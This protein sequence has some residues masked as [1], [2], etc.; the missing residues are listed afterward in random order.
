MN[1]IQKEVAKRRLSLKDLINMG[2]EVEVG[3]QSVV[4]VKGIAG[5]HLAELIER[6][7]A[8]AG[9]LMGQ[10][11]R[12]DQLAVAAPEALAHVIAMAT[13]GVITDEGLQAASELPL[14][15]QTKILE[16]V[17]RQTFTEGFGPFEEQ[18]KAALAVLEQRTK[19]M[20]TKSPSSPNPSSPQDTTP[21]A[22]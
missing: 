11:I 15:I 20:A 13:D 5:K 18:V 3:P 10:G 12:K 22:S 9:M 8:L 2:E 21:P 19:A 16:A 6:F 17:W 14:S 1:K 4:L 7:P